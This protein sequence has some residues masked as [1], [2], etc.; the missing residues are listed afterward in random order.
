MRDGDGLQ[1]RLA[2]LGRTVGA[3][4]AAR[5]SAAERD[6]ARRAE[7]WAFVQREVPE[8]ASLLTAFREVFGRDQVR[9][10]RLVVQGRRIV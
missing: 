10:V 6:R 7:D 9:V 3:A 2:Q 8:T 5:E 1:A 4:Q